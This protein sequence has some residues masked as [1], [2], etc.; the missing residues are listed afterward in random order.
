MGNLS[1]IDGRKWKRL[2][3][4]DPAMH[5]IQPHWQWPSLVQI[6]DSIGSSKTGHEKCIWVPFC[7]YGQEQDLGQNVSSKDLVRYSHSSGEPDNSS[8]HTFTPL[9]NQ[10][11]RSI[12]LK[13]LLLPEQMTRMMSFVSTSD[14]TSASSSWLEQNECS[15]NTTSPTTLSIYFLIRTTSHNDSLKRNGMVFSS[16]DCTFWHYASHTERSSSSPPY[17]AGTT[18]HSGFSRSSTLPPVL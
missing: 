2:W 3:Y 16:R 9:S 5:C 17:P 4:L 14:S 7:S 10:F 18:F 6:P 8:V 15:K 13:S 12:F 1:A 11:L